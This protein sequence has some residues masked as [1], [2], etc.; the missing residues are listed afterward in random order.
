MNSATGISNH[1]PPVPFKPQMLVFLAIS[2]I[3]FKVLILKRKGY[4]QS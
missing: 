1:A 2:V 3:Y 4:P